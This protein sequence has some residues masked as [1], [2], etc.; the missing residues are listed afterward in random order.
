MKRFFVLL[1]CL[2][3]SGF[4]LSASASDSMKSLFLQNADSLYLDYVRVHESAQ[5]GG[6]VM[7]PSSPLSRE[8]FQ[9]ALQ[10]I[11]EVEVW[12]RE[13]ETSTLYRTPVL[14]SYLSCGGPPPCRIGIVAEYDPVLDSDSPRIRQIELSPQYGDD[15]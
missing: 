8:D 2:F 6:Y 12:E 5:E 1:S 10:S 14:S 3:V 9:T 7:H 11:E 13:D 4:H 15:N